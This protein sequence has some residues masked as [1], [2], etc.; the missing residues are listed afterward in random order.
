M[1]EIFIG[2]AIGY[3]LIMVYTYLVEKVIGN[4]DDEGE[5]ENDR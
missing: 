3:V 1:I 5:E 4:F 2:I